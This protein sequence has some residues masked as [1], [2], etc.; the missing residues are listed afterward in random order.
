MV[1]GQLPAL[2]HQLG[3]G[4]AAHSQHTCAVRA[5]MQKRSAVLQRAMTYFH[6]LQV[7]EALLMQ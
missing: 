4:Q 5:A 1:Q 7:P 2:F 6:I 3:L